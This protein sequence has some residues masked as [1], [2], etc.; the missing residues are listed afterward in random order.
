[1]DG[2]GPVECAL[3]ACIAKGT[4]RYEFPDKKRVDASYT[5]NLQELVKLAGL[6]GLRLERAGNAIWPAYS[7][8]LCAPNVPRLTSIRKRKAAFCGSSASLL[9]N[10]ASTVRTPDV[11]EFA[12]SPQVGQ[13]VLAFAR[14]YS[15]SDPKF[16]AGGQAAPPAPPAKLSH[17]KEWLSPFSPPGRNC[18]AIS[19]VL[20][21]VDSA[22]RVAKW[23]AQIESL[24]AEMDGLREKYPQLVQHLERFRTF[25]PAH[26]TTPAGAGAR[27]R[28]EGRPSRSAGTSDGSAPED[29]RE[30]QGFT[31]AQELNAKAEAVAKALRQRLVE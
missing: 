17:R 6:E 20:T 11:V 26:P 16:S 5:H 23:K 31:A 14:S 30:F 7:P 22:S 9:T 2:R 25:P 27:V 12:V 18:G 8:P 13:A 4:E 10:E 19:G 21:V 3:K 28:R 15:S 1:V 24:H 29:G